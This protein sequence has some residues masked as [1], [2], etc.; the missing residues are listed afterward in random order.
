M[1]RELYEHL[2]GIM[3]VG[4]I[5]TSVVLAIPN[6]SYVNLF[7]M[8]QQQLRNIALKVLNAIIL[9]TGYPTNWGSQDPFD[10][11]NI[12]NFGLA[13]SYSSS[14]YLLDPDKVQRLVAENPSGYLEY[15]KVRQLLELQDYGFNLRIAPPFNITVVD[16]SQSEK[17]L[18]FSVTVTLNDEKPVPNAAVTALIVYSHYEGGQ[19]EDERYSI[20][21]VQEQGTTDELGQCTISKVL[22]GQVSDVM[23]AFQITAAGVGT[24]NTVFTGPPPEDIADINMVNDT[25]ILT[26]PKSNPN[27]NRWICDIALSLIH[28]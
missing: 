15:D 5:F 24:V 18:E 28:I 9:E 12:Q 2:F 23:V 10:S 26:H 16:L 25:I 19:G 1:A 20:R 11:S 13:F 17:N 27:E 4:A 8:D 14:F 6:T 7:Y 22:T 21:Q 3:I